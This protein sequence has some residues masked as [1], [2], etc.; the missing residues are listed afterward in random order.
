M[1]SAVSFAHLLGAPSSRRRARRADDDDRTDPDAENDERDDK[2]KNTS[3]RAEDDSRDNDPD[4]ED[5]DETPGARRGRKA[6]RADDGDDDDEF[7]AEDEEDDPKA[8]AAR[9][10]ERARCAAIFGSSAAA[11]RPDLAAHLAFNTSLPRREAVS[12]L[13]EAAKGDA[14]ASRGLASRMADYGDHRVSAS[15]PPPSGHRHVASS[16]D[17]AG[18][19]AGVRAR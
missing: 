6:S 5:E 8:K 13:R 3:S 10:R 15:S 1:G 16:W 7:D 17:A 9:K 18:Q 4:C 12:L 19:R 11:T 2:D 14:K